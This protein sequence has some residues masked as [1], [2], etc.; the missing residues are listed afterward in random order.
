MLFILIIILLFLVNK[1]I[2]DAGKIK[3][4]YS[5]KSIVENQIYNIPITAKD[6]FM[7]NPGAELII[8]EFVNLNTCSEE[9]QEK[10]KTLISFVQKNPTKIKLI[11]KDAPSNSFFIPNNP[12]AHQTL[13]C[14]G[15]QAKFWEFQ[16]K[17]LTKKSNLSV[18]G[19]N[20]VAEELKLNKTLMEKCLNNE[21][22][23]KQVEDNF[24]IARALNTEDN[25]TI[26]MN[27][28][29]INIFEDI[30]FANL[31]TKFLPK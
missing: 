5:D 6:N 19:L 4:K 16:E 20:D 22:T 31:L 29:R 3:L 30:D 28:K 21:E 9:C 7:G 1:E 15:K 26:F 25:P 27:N 17:I 23:I 13:Y 18:A 14:A 2:N 24:N 10:Q 11:W 12:Q 8:T